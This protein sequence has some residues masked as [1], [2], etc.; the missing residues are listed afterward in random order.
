MRRPLLWASLSFLAGVAT[1]PYLGLAF[2]S[3]SAVSLGLAVVS[4]WAAGRSRA[5]AAVLL[6]CVAGVGATAGALS[7]SPPGPGELAGHVGQRVEVEGLAATEGSRF[8]LD[9]ARV[10]FPQG[11]R[12]H[13]VMVRGRTRVAVGDRVRVRG[14]LAPLPEARNPG[15]ADPARFLYRERVRA[16]LVADL[17]VVVESGRGYPVLRW[18]A[19]LRKALQAVYEQVLPPPLNAVL[20]GV[21]LGVPVPD[22]N[23]QQAF[24][25]SGLVHLLVASGAQLSAVA[26]AVYVALRRFRRT[27]RS[28][29]AL[30]AVLAFAVVAGWEPSMA[31]AAV[32]AAVAVAAG[33]SRR[34]VDPAT[35]LG[36][37]AAVLAA[38]HPLLL[39]D[40]GFQLSFAATA[41]LL[42]LS[43]ALQQRLRFGPAWLR[44]GLAAAVSCQVFVFP[45]LLWHFG[46][47]QPW[48][49]AAN[50]LALPASAFLVPVGLLGG[51]VGLVWTP[52]A[53]PLL[54][55][56]QGGCA[57]LV[58]VARAVAD[59]PGATVNLPDAK[60]TAVLLGVWVGAGVAAW[61]GWVRPSRSVLASVVA[62]AV[63]VWVRALPPPPYAE[64][65][66]LDVGQ[67]D[68]VVV[69]GP[70][71]HRVLLDGGPEGEPVTGFLARSGGRV[72]LALLSHPHADHV[73]GLTQA[74]RRFGAGLVLEPG[75]P[76]PTPSY[77]E[78]LRT[79]R[80]RRIPY[81]VAR[82][83]MRVELGRSA[84][85]EV[86]WPPDPLWE[87]PSAVNENSLVVL[88]RYGDARFLFP[89]D[90][91]AGAEGSLVA[92]REDLRAHVLKVPHQGSRTSSSE[93][94]L[95]AVA[96][97][98]AVLS[99]GKANPYGHPHGDVLARYARLGVSL[100]RTDRDGAVTIRTDG[101]NLWVKTMKPG[102]CCTAWWTAWRTR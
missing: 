82:R 80:E 7:R 29:A 73:T 56:A 77:A 94:F 42:F 54:R 75:Y 27:V 68:G 47:L 69:R 10:V 34:E 20:A 87:G 97:R 17:V 32:M 61:R 91:E 60:A 51:L 98:V 48:A 24:R 58:W 53:V 52:L 101:R 64:V 15:E 11:L 16:V 21:V 57:Y 70:E 31:R 26:A 1:G 36:L 18:A 71:G 66:F 8:V 76:H 96:P 95:S 74:L 67:G 6:A 72:D 89:G 90:V 40:V 93:A 30:A 5:A 28:V 23:L 81:R 92:S 83:G 37:A 102:W 63:A 4:L 85:L 100:Y 86:L 41:A 50:V 19:Q 43:P 49:V 14:K 62:L 55:V 3:V 33:L 44:E 13:R 65:V 59:L 84:I 9:A 78:F 38:A 35:L 79:V 99:V 46:H 88:L 2:P 45:L 39:W 25:D 22:R 12:G